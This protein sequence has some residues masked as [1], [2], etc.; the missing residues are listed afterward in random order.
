MSA[1]VL[2][3]KFIISDSDYQTDTTIANTD[4]SFILQPKIDNFSAKLESFIAKRNSLVSK[5]KSSDIKIQRYSQLMPIVQERYENASILRKRDLIS[6][7]QLLEIK[8]ERIETN[9]TLKLEE[10]LKDEVLVSIDALEA[11]KHSLYAETKTQL[12]EE[13][14]SLKRIISNLEQDLVKAKERDYRQILSSPID[15]VVEAISINTEGGVV[16]SAQEIMKIVPLS[17]SI[18]M[19][20]NVKNQDI[21]FIKNGQSVRVKLDTFPFTKYG[22]INGTVQTVSR[23]SILDETLGFVYPVKIKL[24]QSYVSVESDNIPLQSGMQGTAEII[25][26]DRRIISFILSPLAK[27]IQESGRER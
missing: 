6:N 16:T 11:D 26:G 4:I 23:D 22:V 1:S 10:S 17:S 9:S 21:G 13:I 19:N 12:S 27:S 2:F 5:L 7:E 24:D 8:R 18:Q 3:H 20:V 14:E 15:G 25:T